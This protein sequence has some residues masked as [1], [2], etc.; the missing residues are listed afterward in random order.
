MIS[1]TVQAGPMDEIW[2]TYEEPTYK[3]D[4]ILAVSTSQI[5]NCPRHTLLLWSNPDIFASLPS[6]KCIDRLNHDGANATCKALG[7][8]SALIFRVSP[9]EDYTESYWLVENKEL[10]TIKPFKRKFSRGLPNGRLWTHSIKPR[11][12]DMLGCD[13]SSK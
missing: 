6:K 5:S 1:F 11:Q 9:V 13:T 7:F 2:E 10:K 12:F 3:G 4:R 8:K